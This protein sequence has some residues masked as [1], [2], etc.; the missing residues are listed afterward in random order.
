LQPFKTLSKTFYNENDVKPEER[1]T[2][3][4][5]AVRNDRWKYVLYIWYTKIFM[6]HINFIW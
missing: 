4:L 3:T 1:F 6:I 2:W 5:G